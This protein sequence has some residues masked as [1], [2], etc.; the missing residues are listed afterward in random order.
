MSIT[1]SSSGGTSKSG[2]RRR[3]GAGAAAAVGVV[4][5]AGNASGGP[6]AT[7]TSGTRVVSSNAN[8][9][10]G[11]GRS[12]FLS[13]SPNG[14]QVAFAST[15][16]NLGTAN[17]GHQQVYVKDLRTGKVQLVS[18]SSA[19][20]PGNGN[21]QLTAEWS[22]DGTRIIFGSAASNLVPHYK[23]MNGS[24]AYIK[25]LR[26]GNTITLDP[27]A[28]SEAD[29]AT[30]SPDGRYIA[31]FS[32]LLTKWKGKWD[33]EF[34]VR[35]VATGKVSVLSS[36]ASGEPATD[37]GCYL[38]CYMVWSPTGSEIAFTS[39]MP[40]LITAIGS[41]PYQSPHGAFPT[42]ELFVKNVRTGKL[43]VASSTKNGAVANN[44]SCDYDPP[45]WSPDGTR[46]VFDSWSSNLA[47]GSG[48]PQ[49]MSVYMKNLTTGGVD[50]VTPSNV[51]TFSYYAGG[52]SPDGSR[53][54]YETSPE[55]NAD[56]LPYVVYVKNL[57]SGAQVT[58]TGAV[59]GVRAPTA[60]GFLGFERDGDIVLV[61]TSTARKT[62]RIDISTVDLADQKTTL[63]VA[64]S[65]PSAGWD[66][67]GTQVAYSNNSA[68][69]QVLL[70]PVG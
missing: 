14:Q 65:N 34:Y 69:S 61:E 35:N 9:V 40:N 12:V 7:P 46:I 60:T 24:S 20:I 50:R 49:T 53:V 23:T 10:R 21:A 42:S 27:R 29:D 44:D 1:T 31:F 18:S 4:L 63:I 16:T 55:Q 51:D 13:F 64:G 67:V 58:V 30:W 36:S 45:V 2:V 66:P 41:K 32:N 5:F 59:T 15:A 3:L 26:T 19:G 22:P 54:A 52:W 56:P 8:E 39:R 33:N 6:A 68:H 47:A 43:T 38:A 62:S 25:D 57:S 48:G 28:D 17:D 11:N 37:F 70:R